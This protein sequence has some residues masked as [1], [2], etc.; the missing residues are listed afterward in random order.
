MAP[1]AQLTDEEKSC[2]KSMQGKCDEMGMSPS[3]HSCCQPKTTSTAR[4]FVAQLK[5]ARANFAPAVAPAVFAPSNPLA[6]PTA[7]FARSTNLDPSPPG[8]K[9]LPILRI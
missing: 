1:A 3:S 4:P 6:Q 7:E 9:S 2:C 5:I 8:T